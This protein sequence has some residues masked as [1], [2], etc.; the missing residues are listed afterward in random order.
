MLQ[1]N[2]V[3]FA[4]VGM[5]GRKEGNGGT[6]GGWG[7]DLQLMNF[8]AARLSCLAALSSPPGLTH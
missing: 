7:G 6:H 5:H 1:A 2:Q 3:Q 8:G 4:T